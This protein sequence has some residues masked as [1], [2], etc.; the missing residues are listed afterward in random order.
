MKDH[1]SEEPR[2][3][4]CNM[5]N[6]GLET[7]IQPLQVSINTQQKVTD[8]KECYLLLRS[9]FLIKSEIQTL[10]GPQGPPGLPGPKGINGLIGLP[11]SKGENGLTGL[12]GTKGVHGVPGSD[13][14]NGLPGLT[15]PKGENGVSGIKGSPGS[16]GPPGTRGSPGSRGPS[17]QPGLLGSKGESGMKG[18]YGQM[19]PRGL[20]GPTG[21][22][23]RR[24]RRGIRGPAGPF[25]P[26]GVPGSDGVNGLP[27][28]TGPKGENGV[29]GMKC[30]S[31]ETGYK[32]VANT[33][34]FFDNVRRL[35]AEAIVNCAS[36]FPSG[37]RFVE[38]RTDEVHELILKESVSYF[39]TL[40]VWLGVEYSSEKDAYIYT[41]DEA[42]VV[43]NNWST[44]SKRRA[45]NWYV[46][47][48]VVLGSWYDSW[49]DK[50]KAY[51]ICEP[52]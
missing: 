14:V 36:K 46:V 4:F 48:G 34:Y 7:E 42:P 13:G 32:L 8:Y 33:C 12:P 26:M 19:G 6:H 20:P 52:K 18:E 45:E 5:E 15:G 2:L 16:K 51:S 17:G 35:R 47:F 37:G 27:G 29:S 25:G 49:N 50:G 40:Y 31:G 44:S 43:M 22:A 21:A 39:T 30:Q 38:P 28:L 24:G 1:S 3:A 9:V 11:G 10:Q 41:S 23:G